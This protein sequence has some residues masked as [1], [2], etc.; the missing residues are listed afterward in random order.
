[1]TYDLLRSPDEDFLGSGLCL[2]LADPA[3]PAANDKDLLDIPEPL[4]ETL[5]YVLVERIEQVID[6]ALTDAPNPAEPEMP[7]GAT[8]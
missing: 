2:T 4:R 8:P 1:M 7:G 3:V 6:L 5:E